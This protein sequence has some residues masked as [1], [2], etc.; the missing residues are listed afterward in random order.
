MRFPEKLQMQAGGLPDRTDSSIAPEPR[1]I[2]QREGKPL[3]F[4]RAAVVLC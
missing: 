3:D 2:V 4:V 1:L